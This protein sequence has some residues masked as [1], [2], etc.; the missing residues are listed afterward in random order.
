MV[1]VAKRFTDNGI[2]KESR[3]TI[4]TVVIFLFGLIII[5][6]LFTL[7]IL[8]NSFYSLLATE[9]HEI[10]RDLFPQRGSIYVH[11]GGDL[12]PLVT[13]KDYYLVYAE[14]IKIK[15]PNTVIDKITPILGLEEE[16]WKALLPKL[17]QNDD[18][19][20]PIKHKVSPEQVE[21]IESLGLE[22]IGFLPETYR[23][24]PEKSIGGHIFGFVGFQSDERVG[25]YG[26]EGYFN[27]ELSGKS[28]LL[29]SVKDAL[30]SLVTIGPRSIQSAEDG[31]DLVLTIDRQVQFFACQKLKEFFDYFQSE[32]GS[33]I[34][35]EPK[36]GAIIAMCSLPDFNPEYYNEVEDINYLNN[37]AIFYD[38]EPGSVFKPI[39]MAAALELGEIE[40]DTTY[41]DTGEVKVG[42]FT[43][44]NFDNQA[45]GIKTMTEVLELSLNTGAMFAAEKIGKDNFREFVEAFGFGQPTGLTLDKEVAGDI[46]PLR[47]RGDV[48]YLTASFGQ[49][50]TVTPLQL[51]TAFSAIANQGKL[52][53]P[54]IVSEIIKSNG[55]IIKTEPQAVRQVI[56]PKT[57]TLLT[58]ML[59]S[60]VERSYD[61]KARVDGY[62]IAGKT[63]TASVPSPRG[64]YSNETIHTFVGF[65]PVSNPR[66]VMLTKLDKNKTGPGFA[67]DTVTFL[68]SQIAEFLLNYYQIPPDY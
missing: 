65:G 50:I 28:G 48:Y 1:S 24:Y 32:K 3:I 13:N 52:V 59:T 22:G 55:E 31:V 64:G 4:L 8:Q 66:F 54:Y 34:I 60:T 27:Q 57:A 29:K 35:M 43:I 67:S 63:G 36:T 51:I 56:A 58:A 42:P 15:S 20:E 40:P 38:Y 16:E 2:E 61:K 46:S 62:Y 12:Y 9:K 53:K 17:A 5:G 21:Q 33:V 49:G 26:L 68:F 23:Y 39:T 45:H 7:Q 37:P 41:E 47:K 19:Y 44:R 11:E 6:R 10:Y 30:G 14:P 25:Q 18:P